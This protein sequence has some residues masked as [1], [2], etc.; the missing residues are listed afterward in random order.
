MNIVNLTPHDIIL[1]LQR[2]IQRTFPSKGIVHVESDKNY[3]GIQIDGHRVLRRRQYKI[4]G[5]PKPRHRTAF[6]VSRAA[7]ERIWSTEDRTDVFVLAGQITD[8]RGKLV[9][10]RCLE[11]N[12]YKKNI[13]IPG[14][15]FTKEQ[16]AQRHE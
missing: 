3:I 14:V 1:V 4:R 7:A 12:P 11:A 8:R 6:I 13:D 15:D 5:L 16:G 10:F 2:N 9:G